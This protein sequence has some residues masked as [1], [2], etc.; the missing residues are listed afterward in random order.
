MTGSKG[1][2]GTQRKMC[3]IQCVHGAIQVVPGVLCVEIVKQKV[4][5][6]L[7]IGVLFGNECAMNRIEWDI[8]QVK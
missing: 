6:G 4:K 5:H 7:K 2:G 8:K 3:A 1:E